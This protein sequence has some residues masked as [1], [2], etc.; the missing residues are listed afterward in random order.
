ME[1]LSLS[2]YAYNPHA[3]PPLITGLAILLLG[4]FV[5]YKN[6]KDLKHIVFFIFT[7]SIAIWQISSFFYHSAVSNDIAYWWG[8]YI[9]FFGLSFI[10]IHPYYFSVLMFNLKN[11]RK[12]VILGYIIGAIFCIMQ[13]STGYVFS[14]MKRV[15][16]GYAG[17]LGPLGAYYLIFFYTYATALLLNF[18]LGYRRAVTDAER[19]KLKYLFVGILVATIGSID[20]I[21]M[22]GYEL[23]QFGYLFVDALAVIMAYTIVRHRLLDIETV[24]HKTLLWLTILVSIIVSIFILIVMLRSWVETFSNIQ[25]TIFYTIIFF[26]L[27]SAFNRL[28]P[29]IDHFLQRRKYK[30]EAV[31]IKF[32]KD[33]SLIKGVEELADKIINTLADVFY[34]D[35]SIILFDEDYKK[36]ML[37]KG[38]SNSIIKDKVY[39]PDAVLLKWLRD[40]D[41]V[42]EAEQIQIDPAYADIKDK[43]MIYFESL[44]AKICIPLVFYGRLLGLLTLGKKGSL[45][46]FTISDIKLLSMFRIEAAVALSNSLS[47][48]DLQML[49]GELENKVRE[50]TDELAKAYIELKKEHEKTKE[51]ARLKSL[52]IANVSHELRT[53]LSSIIGFSE[54]LGNKDFGELTE[55]QDKYLNTIQKSSKHLLHLINNVLDL[56]KIDAGKMP[57]TVSEFSISDL[58]RDAVEEFLPIVSKKEIKLIT[59]FKDKLPEIAAD[60]VKLKEVIDN[61]L[62]N[63]VKFTPM[64]GTVKVKARLIQPSAFR[65]K[66]SKQNDFNPPSDIHY[67]DDLNYIYVSVEDSGIGIKKE[68]VDRIFDAFEQVD[69]SYTKQYQGTGLGLA[70]VKRYVELHKGR[71]WV[72]SE[73]GKG[74]RFSFIIPE[75]IISDI[76]LKKTTFDLYKMLHGI[77]YMMSSETEAKKVKIDFRCEWSFGYKI[78]ADKELLRGIL[79]NII[80]N[81][82]RF[83]PMDG[84]VIVELKSI[85]RRYIISIGNQGDNKYG[86]MAYSFFV[87]KS[88]YDISPKI[89]VGLSDAKTIIEAHGGA[90][91]VKND[92]EDKITWLEISIPE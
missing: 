37:I 86:G 19:L 8:R 92:T 3:I 12:F 22:S 31:F 10:H 59:E 77:I 85:G 50:R 75:R 61:L 83:S 28:K 87:P 40:Y 15:Y 26:I 25:Q 69:S 2:N 6:I 30:A 56:S 71:I 65:S 42:I 41:D 23:Y 46:P 84:S 13:V 51:V 44:N 4:I 52:F 78:T 76:A 43:A 36:C 74:S 29:R 34:A 33:I 57:V 81:A 90:I 27:L 73:L 89:C 45:R 1:I 48:T 80:N 9:L 18:Y 67:K 16:W 32:I 70:I 55:K 39:L 63:A 38:I 35:T 53:P 62:S 14:D 49:K 88:D 20:F 11:Q 47:Y 24:G 79:I 58:L 72:E 60:S 5:L 17:V 68:D 7:V 66:A 54:L 21:A 91:S 64:A 82:V